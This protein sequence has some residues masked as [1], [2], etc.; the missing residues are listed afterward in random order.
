[1]IKVVI[2]SLVVAVLLHLPFL[3]LKAQTPPV[4]AGKVWVINPGMSDEF[5]AA[6]VGDM[7]RVYDKADSWDRT[8]AFD[9]R[10]QEIKRVEEEDGSEN[11]ILAMNP[12]WYAEEDVFT[13]NGRTYYFAGGG[14]QTN[15]TTIFGYMEVRIKPSDFPMGSGVFMFTRDKTPEACGEAYYTELDIIENMSYTGPG[16]SDYW[17]GYQHVNTHVWPTDENCNRLSST[18]WKGSSRVLEGPLD[19]NVVGAW[20]VDK[21]SVQFYLN[22][23][24]WHTVEYLKDSYMP[25]PLIL[26]METY[27]WGSDENNAD[28]PKPEEYMFQD[29][30]RTPEQRAV[31]YDWVRTWKLVDIDTSIFNSQ[32]DTVGFLEKPLSLWANSILEVTHLYSATEDRLLALSL[33]DKADMLL[34]SDT[35]SVEAGVDSYLHRLDV[36]QIL[37]AGEYVL[38]NELLTANGS[39]SL[40]ASDTCLLSVEVEPVETLLFDT[41][42]PKQVYPSDSSYLLDVYY[43]G[44]SNMEIAVEIRDP[45][46]I[47]I[48]GGLQQVPD[49]EGV[50]TIKADLYDN[51]THVGSGYYWKSHIR[52]RGTTWRESVHGLEFLPFSVMAEP[53]WELELQSEGWPLDDTARSLELSVQFE[54]LADGKLQVSLGRMDKP[55]LA[56]TTIDVLQGE[57]SLSFFLNFREEAEAADDYMIAGVLREAEGMEVL[58]SDTIRDL[59]FKEVVDTTTSV[60][61][62][63][64]GISDLRVYP[65]PGN[66]SIRIELPDPGQEIESLFVTDISGRLI[67]ITK[68]S[69]TELDVSLLE[70]GTYIIRVTTSKRN[71]Q[72]IFIKK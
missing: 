63:Q 40:L 20:W 58:A 33:Y 37:V 55:I 3:G 72:T 45:A 56:D 27:S 71:Y 49:G 8:A 19:F 39:D 35:I 12:M 18:Q 23:K 38:V 44:A 25:M 15:A 68:D 14:M 32:T 1:M 48:G 30:F 70:R 26:T 7:W 64:A 46:G 31:Y 16:A 52:P 67:I 10:I 50:A 65:N 47:W 53:V 69:G 54:A 61:G 5:S 22:G 34:A 57:A 66:G 51:A 42:F 17:N 21:D 36:G 24:H 59:E 62:T 2:R 11:F 9:K 60:H 6:G 41:G 43:Q 4:P 13:K 29:D 28:N